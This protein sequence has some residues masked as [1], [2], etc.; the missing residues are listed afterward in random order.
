MLTFSGN[1]NILRNVNIFNIFWNLNGGLGISGLPE[2]ARIG[3]V[4]VWLG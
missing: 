1:V 3:I 2:A 4:T